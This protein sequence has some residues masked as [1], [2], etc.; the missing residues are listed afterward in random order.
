MSTILN[1]VIWIA[2]RGRIDRLSY[3]FRLDTLFCLSE[4][5]RIAPVFYRMEDWISMRRS[6]LWGDAEQSELAVV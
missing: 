6:A 5:N 1:S 2:R 4:W 3:A